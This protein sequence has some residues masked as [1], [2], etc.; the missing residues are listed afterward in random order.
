MQFQA[1]P[2]G[3]PWQDK[4]EN[5]IIDFSIHRCGGGFTPGQTARAMM[6][7]DDIRAGKIWR[8]HNIEIRALPGAIEA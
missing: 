2:I 4:T 5:Q 6:M 7:M 8:G 1:R 3:E